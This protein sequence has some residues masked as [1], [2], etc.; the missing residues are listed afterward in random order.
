MPDQK[1]NSLPR[2]F[3]EYLILSIGILIY[4]SG[5]TIFLTPNNLVGGGVSGIGAIIQYATGVKMGYTYFAINA[6]LLIVAF[7]ILGSSFGAK[8]IYGIILASFL[9]N[10]LQV[11]IPQTVIQ[12]FARSQTAS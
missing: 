1:K 5:W 6:I 9:L 12:D 11:I 8:T 3:K 10:F 2:L 4:T 7:F